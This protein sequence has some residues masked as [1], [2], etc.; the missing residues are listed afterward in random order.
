[1]YINLY[2]PRVWPNYRAILLRGFLSCCSR[3]SGVPCSS[4]LRGVQ[5][6]QICP[7]PPTASSPSPKIAYSFGSS[8]TENCRVARAN[9]FT[10]VSINTR[11]YSNVSFAPLCADATGGY[12]ELF[13]NTPY[14]IFLHASSSI[15]IYLG[16]HKSN[17]CLIK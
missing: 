6:T 15:A 4:W 2:I 1:M 5:E 12:A 14:D 13:F 7:S 11:R 17:L 9:I 8:Y 16:K 10:S 3:L